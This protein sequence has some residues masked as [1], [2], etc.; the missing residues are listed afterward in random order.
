[1]N[2]GFRLKYTIDNKKSWQPPVFRVARNAGY[3]AYY[4]VGDEK[5]V[6][7]AKNIDLFI[8]PSQGILY[9]VWQ[10]SSNYNYPIPNSGYSPTYP[11][12]GQ[13]N[14][15]F[16]DPQPNKKTF[17]EFAQTFVKSTINIRDRWYSSDGKTSG[18]PDL[19]NIFYKYLLSQQTV[20]IPNDNFTYQKLIE[21]VQG[22]GSYW[23]RLTQQMIPAST[24][25]NTGVKFENSALQRQK[26][27]Y[28]RQ[29]G[30]QIINKLLPRGGRISGQSNTATIPPTIQS[31]TLKNT[32]NNE[33][34]EIFTLP[35]LNGNLNVSSFSDILYNELNR[36]LSSV[37][38]SVSTC[39]GVNSLTSEWYVDLR[40]GNNV[41]INKKFYTG[42][43]IIDTPTNTNWDT[44]LFNF[45]PDIIN[46]GL[47]YYLN[48]NKL[49][50]VNLGNQLLY[51]NQTLTLNVGININLTC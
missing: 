9:N 43:G 14:W 10:M 42:F 34:T 7:N 25:W 20:G 23:I 40:I 39:Q 4:T 1:M 12:L 49:K 36:V 48:N 41:L 26:F 5:L 37:G 18:Y 19:L 13:N 45:L 11:S 31:S 6:L 24:I 33:F 35:W 30:C 47:T 50:V 28:R 8:N 3:E 2:L 15:T 32:A 29:R 27:V 21:Y 44:A 38:Q 46:S 51:L 16:I 22:I 17:F